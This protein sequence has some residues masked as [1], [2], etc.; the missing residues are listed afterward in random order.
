MTTTFVIL[1]AT[2]VV[3]VWGRIRADLVAL[4]SMLSLLL[5]GPL[6]SGKRCPAFP[7]RRS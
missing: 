2:I 1:A 4:L 7:I 6:T 3:F 5:L